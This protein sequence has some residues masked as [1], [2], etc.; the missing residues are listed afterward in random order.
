[1][2]G[3]W[4][5]DKIGRRSVPASGYEDIRDPAMG[6]KV[7]RCAICGMP[8]PNTLVGTWD[9]DGRAYRVR[10]CERC[11]GHDVQPNPDPLTVSEAA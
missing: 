3:R 5:D 4:S 2:A 10:V 9:G 6:E 7:P 1:M 8:S 11:I